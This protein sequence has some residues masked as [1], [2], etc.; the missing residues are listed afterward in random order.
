LVPSIPSLRSP[1]PFLSHLSPRPTPTTSPARA[2]LLSAAVTTFV[3][4]PVLVL[5]RSTLIIEKRGPDVRHPVALSG[6]TCKI[7]FHDPLDVPFIPRTT[8]REI[9]PSRVLL[10][11][12]LDPF[13]IA[14]CEIS[15]RCNFEWAGYH[16]TPPLSW[17]PSPSSLLRPRSRPPAQVYDGSSRRSTVLAGQLQPLHG[18]EVPAPTAPTAA[19]PDAYH[20]WPPATGHV[21][22]VADDAQTGRD[23]LFA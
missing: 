7:P 19:L 3:T 22:P 5:S 16:Q 10:L 4:T 6:S 12:P 18:S 2:S 8:T 20:H 11:A 21:P 1:S 13:V 9:R 15:G 23:W 17:L 14:G